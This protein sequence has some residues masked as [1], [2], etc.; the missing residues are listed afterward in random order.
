MSANLDDNP[1]ARPADQGERRRTRLREFQS[2]LVERMQAARAGGQAHASQLG[3]QIGAQ[4]WLVSLQQAGEI[5]PVPVITPVPLTQDWFLGVANIRG[6]LVTVVDLA[7]FHGHAG[8]PLDKDC[9]ILAFSP[10][11]SFNA[12]L[13]ASRVLGLRNMAQMQAAG[14][15]GSSMLY[16]DAEGQSWQQLDLAALTRD[17]R[18]LHI[19]I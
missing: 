18:F 9:R 14:E 13:L 8:T 17:P 12:G 3:I 19:G 4:R 2:Q 16:V 10:S 11:L 5:V 7:S 6:N 1:Q 15:E